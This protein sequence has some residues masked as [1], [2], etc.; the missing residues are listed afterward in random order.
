MGTI[1]ISRLLPVMKAKVIPIELSYPEL[2]MRHGSESYRLHSRQLLV[3][4]YKRPDR[5][6]LTLQ[7]RPKTLTWACSRFGSR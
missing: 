1:G 4:R 6:R 7:P 5:C 3:R 2:R